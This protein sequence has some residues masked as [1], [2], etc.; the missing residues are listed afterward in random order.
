MEPKVFISVGS[1]ATEKQ[2]DATR[3][4]FSVLRSAGLSPCQMGKNEWSF[5]QP[6][7]AV[8]RVIGECDG[9]AVIAFSRYEFKQGTE[10]T[11]SGKRALVDVRMP[12]VWNQIEAAMAY[13]KNL[14]LLVIAEHGLKT[15]GLLEDRYDWAIY[16]TDFDPRDF[17]SKRFAAWVGTWKNA[18]FEHARLRPIQDVSERL[19]PSNVTVGTYLR[20]LTVPQLWA[21]LS[22]ITGVLIAVATVGYLIGASKWPWQ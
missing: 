10:Q 15:D 22:A 5:E 1:N 12:T 6:L 8:R 7:K 19:D 17:H 9:I 21:L 13:T 2:Q 3:V 16:W 11:N 14:P 20:Q 18:V 4:V